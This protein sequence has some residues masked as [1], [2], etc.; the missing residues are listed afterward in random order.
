V[1]PNVLENHEQERRRAAKYQHPGYRDQRAE[2]SPG[3]L[4]QDVA[5]SSAKIGEQKWPVQTR[6]SD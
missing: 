5:V 1:L 4:Q 2:M 6:I 3:I